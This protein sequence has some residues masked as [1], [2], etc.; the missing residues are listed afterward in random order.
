MTLYT[1]EYTFE[2]LK[3]PIF[4]NFSVPEQTVSSVQGSSVEL[5][6]NLTAANPDDKVRLVLW[7]KGD[8]RSPIY[9]YDTRGKSHDQARHWSNGTILDGRA[10]FRYVH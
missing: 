3:R 9:T 2:I 6:C 4:P 1:T 5:P 8:S 7:F 10:F